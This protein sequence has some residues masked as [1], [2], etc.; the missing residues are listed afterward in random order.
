MRMRIESVVVSW[1]RMLFAI[2]QMEIN[3]CETQ[4]YGISSSSFL[5]SSEK[6]MSERSVATSRQS[7]VDSL[8]IDR[9]EDV[10]ALFRPYSSPYGTTVARL[11]IISFMMRLPLSAS[12]SRAIGRRRC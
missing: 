1:W 2:I 10:S 4:H 6:L 9:R 3:S 12:Q 5:I 11:F 7:T 8:F